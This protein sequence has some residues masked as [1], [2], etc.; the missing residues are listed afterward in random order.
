MAYED[1][2]RDKAIKAAIPPTQDDP[3]QQLLDKLYATEESPA[4]DVDTPPTMDRY[5][6]KGPGKNYTD[7]F[8]PEW[9][10]RLYDDGSIEI[11]AAP[12]TSTIK[13]PYTPKRG[14][15]AY[16]AIFKQVRGTVPEEPTGPEAPT[17]A[18]E[19]IVTGIEAPKKEVDSELAAQ[20]AA[21]EAEISPARLFTPDPAG[22]KLRRRQKLIDEDAARQEKYR[23]E[24]PPKDMIVRADEY[25][26]TGI[27]NLGKVG[28]QSLGELTNAVVRKIFSGD[29]IT[30]SNEKLLAEQFPE[31]T[32][33]G[34]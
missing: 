11:I 4:A 20:V 19:E 18:V 16:E 23:R 12:E 26:Q 14:G 10:Y 8:D 31:S 30:K 15:L 34:E 29:H 22:E 28:L 24:G 17:E 5:Y 2:L 3:D 27:G 13:L 25:L 9:S 6:G 7:K 32:G 21:Q 33:R 1:E